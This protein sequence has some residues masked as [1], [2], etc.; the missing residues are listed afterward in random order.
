[1]PQVSAAFCTTHVEADHGAGARDPVGERDE[2]VPLDE[3]DGLTDG[4]LELGAAV[5][6]QP[7]DRGGEGGRRGEAAAGVWGGR[8]Q[9]LVGVLAGLKERE[10]G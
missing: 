8:R 10:G 2:G 7:G 9:Q 3:A 4:G 1:M 5:P 6:R